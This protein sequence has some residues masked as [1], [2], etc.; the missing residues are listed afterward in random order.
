MA[1]VAEVY[2]PFGFLG[3]GGEGR[4]SSLTWRVGG[5]GG[6]G[7]AGGWDAISA[8]FKGTEET[9]LTSVGFVRS[10]LSS[11]PKK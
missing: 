6:G 7:G 8:P 10:D 5:G 4:R 3:G 2:L 11:P 9:I 1:A